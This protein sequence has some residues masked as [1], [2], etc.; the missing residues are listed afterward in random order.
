MHQI[1]AERM[2]K[3]YNWKAECLQYTPNHLNNITLS[4]LYYIPY[5]FHSILSTLWYIQC[6]LHCTLYTELSTLYPL[7]S[8]FSSTFFAVFLILYFILQ[9]QYSLLPNTPPFYF[10][11]L[12][13]SMPSSP[14]LSIQ[15]I[16]SSLS[17]TFSLFTLFLR[18][19][20]SSRLTSSSLHYPLSSHSLLLLLI[21]L[22]ILL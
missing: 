16:H 22:L 17:L 6:T 21:L 7:P 11:L 20:Q 14:M 3:M 13:L 12:P 18:P 10:P 19:P 8:T 5:S 2:S 4:T 1:Y 9:D 15:Y